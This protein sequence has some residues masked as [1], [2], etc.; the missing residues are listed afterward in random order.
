[1]TEFYQELRQAPI[2]TEALRQAQLNLLQGNE[3]WLDVARQDAAQANGEELIALAEIDLEQLTHPYYWSAF[4]VI[5][6]PW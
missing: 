1:M 5:G 3:Q 6:S 4:T 2:K